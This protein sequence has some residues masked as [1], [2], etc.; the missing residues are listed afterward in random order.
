MKCKMGKMIHTDL[1]RRGVVIGNDVWIVSGVKVLDGV[2]I[3]G[4]TIIAAGAV[5]TKSIT[6]PGIYGG[7]PAT[8]I[9]SHFLDGQ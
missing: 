5:V 1:R 6:V 2:T 3:V 4:N 7:V 9:K 8:L